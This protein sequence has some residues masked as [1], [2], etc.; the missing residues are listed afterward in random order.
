MTALDWRSLPIHKGYTFGCSLYSPG[1]VSNPKGH[2][3]SATLA[4]IANPQG[5]YIWLFT[6]FPGDCQQ[7]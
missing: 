5:E 6:P 7:P 4:L 3:G 1:I 2:D